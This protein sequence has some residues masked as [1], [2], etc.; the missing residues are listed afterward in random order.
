[1][2]DGENRVDRET[3]AVSSTWDWLTSIAKKGI[4]SLSSNALQNDAD[5]NENVSFPDW[6]NRTA[7]DANSDCWRN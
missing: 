1:M 4:R 3:H 2:S 6:V 7:S 5:S